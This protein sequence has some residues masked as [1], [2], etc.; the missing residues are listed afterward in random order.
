MGDLGV[1]NHGSTFSTASK[2]NPLPA[3]RDG[4]G[5]FKD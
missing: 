3:F 4:K 5:G 2:E 1:K